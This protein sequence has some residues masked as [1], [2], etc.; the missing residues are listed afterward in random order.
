MLTQ[1]GRWRDRAKHRDTEKPHFSLTQIGRCEEKHRNTERETNKPNIKDREM[2]KDTQGD[3]KKGVTQRQKRTRKG[4]EIQRESERETERST[5][6][7]RERQRETETHHLHANLATKMGRETF[8]TYK[9][10]KR[11]KERE[12]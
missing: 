4:R 7:H 6:T 8:E 2:G 1:T 3:S 11:E 10:T 5:A 12:Q 9:E